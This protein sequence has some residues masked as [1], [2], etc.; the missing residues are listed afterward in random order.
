MHYREIMADRM[1]DRR[2]ENN[3]MNKSYTHG[4]VPM[5]KLEIPMLMARTLDGG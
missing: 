5:P 2:M 1:N 3:S 4:V